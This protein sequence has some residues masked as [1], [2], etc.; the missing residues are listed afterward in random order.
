MSSPAYPPSIYF[1]LQVALPTAYIA[2]LLIK[3]VTA[4]SNVSVDAD[5]SERNCWTG[6]T[7]LIL[8]FTTVINKLRL[9][10][11]WTG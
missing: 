6:W 7:S 9:I 2:V 5:E 10:A 8:I 3:S 11:S 1:F 4:P